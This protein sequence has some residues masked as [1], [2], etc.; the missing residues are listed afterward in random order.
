MSC[1]SLSKQSTVHFPKGPYGTLSNYHANKV[2]S[3]SFALMNSLPRST[4][5]YTVPLW[6]FRPS[7]DTLVKGAAYGSY[8]N[9]IDAYG[10]GAENCCP[11]YGTPQNCDAPISCQPCEADTVEPCVCNPDMSAPQFMPRY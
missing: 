3:S 5:G 4:P 10:S 2:N 7:Y 11:K 9:I 8:P 6:N 1:N